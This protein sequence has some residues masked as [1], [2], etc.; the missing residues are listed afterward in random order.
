MP[1]Y[2]YHSSYTRSHNSTSHYTMPHHPTLYPSASHHTTAQ[3]TTHSTLNHTTAYHTMPHYVT[4][5]TST[6]HCICNSINVCR[7][8]ASY[9]TYIASSA[10]AHHHRR[11]SIN[12]QA[13]SHS[14]H[15]PFL[16]IL[17]YRLCK[18]TLLPTFGGVTVSHACMCHSSQANSHIYVYHGLWYVATATNN[19]QENVVGV[20]QGRALLC[21]FT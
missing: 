5:H 18:Q 15:F 2:T 17:L 4:L 11:L 20:I 16:P 1:R 8:V 6:Q 10:T 3:H 7:Y 9:C 12:G 19:A 13:P 14:P 21:L